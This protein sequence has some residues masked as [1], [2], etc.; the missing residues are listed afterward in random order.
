MRPRITTAA[1][2]EASSVTAELTFTHPSALARMKAKAIAMNF[3]PQ[4]TI[5]DRET[6]VRRTLSPSKCDTKA[7][8]RVS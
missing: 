4:V 1:P 8:W 6:G 5:Q 2:I 7:S 3:T